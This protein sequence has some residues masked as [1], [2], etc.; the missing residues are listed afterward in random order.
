MRWKV[1]FLLNDDKDKPDDRLETFGFKS[2]RVPPSC[3]KM[4]SIEKD[5]F[6]MIPS[7]KF[8]TI[9]NNFQMKLKED[10]K[11]V[12]ISKRVFVFADK[13]NNLYEMTPKK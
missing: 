10:A 8:K 11:K 9:K 3:T 13:T 5:L 2:R 12:R 7:I 6:N 4:E 1:L